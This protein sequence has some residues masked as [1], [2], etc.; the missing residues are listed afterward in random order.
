M[1]PEFRIMGS[2]ADA[3]TLHR[4]RIETVSRM[5]E[6]ITKPGAPSEARSDGFQGST[7]RLR[8]NNAAGL[9]SGSYEPGCRLV[10]VF[11]FKNQL[12]K[13]IYHGFPGI[14][15]RV[16]FPPFSRAYALSQSYAFRALILIIYK[17]LL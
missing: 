9:Q 5:R 3:G 11:W 14:C 10:F 12:S 17:Y 4:L 2:K 13:N 8:R 16:H 15:T 1:I 6:S 7:A